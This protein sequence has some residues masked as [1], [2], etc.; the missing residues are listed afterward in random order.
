MEKPM[1]KE[2]NNLH[3]FSEALQNLDEYR[4]GDRF[5]MLQDNKVVLVTISNV[6]LKVWEASN[7]KVLTIAYK[8]EAKTSAFGHAFTVKT[9][10][11]FRSKEE[12]VNSFLDSNDVPKKLIRDLDPN[13]TVKQLLEYLKTVDP[14]TTIENERIWREI[15]EEID[16]ER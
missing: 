5:F 3:E 7:N 16:K 8:L 9:A 10:Q 13:R 14:E 12:A 4:V 11:L 2:H 15:T 1:R 6:S